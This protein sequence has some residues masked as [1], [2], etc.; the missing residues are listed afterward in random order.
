VSET[1]KLA[2]LVTLSQTQSVS[3]IQVEDVGDVGLGGDI[4]DKITAFIEGFD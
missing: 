1:R 4:L 3:G 2:T